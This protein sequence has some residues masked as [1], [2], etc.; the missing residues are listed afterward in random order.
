LCIFGKK[1]KDPIIG[2]SSTEGDT[3][4]GA[5]NRNIDAL[6]GARSLNTDDSSGAKVRQNTEL[7]K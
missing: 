3:P 2:R 4:A 1:K 6:S 5:Q 7:S